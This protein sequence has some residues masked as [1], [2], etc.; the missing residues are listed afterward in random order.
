MFNEISKNVCCH[1]P[2]HKDLFRTN[3]VQHFTQSI[4]D[5]SPVL[6]RFHLCK[7][8]LV[9]HPDIRGNAD[10]AESRLHL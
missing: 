5:S 8:Q 10:V 4:V 7:E 6:S 3:Y 9:I 1:A 2:I